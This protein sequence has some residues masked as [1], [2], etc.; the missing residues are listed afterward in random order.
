MYLELKK[1]FKE[2]TRIKTGVGEVERIQLWV[3]YLGANQ[4]FEAFINNIRIKS[5]NII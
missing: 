2:T 1:S 5:V 3:Q 4:V